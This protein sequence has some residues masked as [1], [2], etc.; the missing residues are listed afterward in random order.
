MR[1]SAFRSTCLAGVVAL[2]AI[3]GLSA[4]SKPKPVAAGNDQPLTASVTKVETKTLDGGLSA[5]GLLVSREEV[6][7]TTEL[8]GYRVAKVLVDQGA[9]VTQGQPLVQLDDTLLRSQLAQSQA[10]VASQEANSERADA[11][12]RRVSGLDN[13]GVLSQEQIEE[14]RLAARTA[15]AQLASARAQLA[16]LKVREGMMTIRAPFAG[17]LL[18]KTVRPGDVATPS[19]VMFR[20]TRGG[21]VELNA[22]V[23][24]ASLAEVHP[25]QKAQVVLADGTAVAGIVRL[26][27]PQV[28]QATKL[29]H[30]RITL[31]QREDIRPG[32]FARATFT[33]RGKPVPV[34]PERALNYDAKGASVMVLG[35]GDR[36]HRVE[37]KTGERSGGYV[38][39]LSG[40]E[41][42]ATVV[43]GGASFLLDG[44]HVRPS[45]TGT[46]DARPASGATRR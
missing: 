40:P 9:V 3:T 41:P 14:R 36:V 43:L 20:M 39:I 4:C 30:A 5:S 37:V 15:K 32:G 6:A 24:E 26:V 11:E 25:G 17:R 31:P 16:D 7:I 18:D 42:G 44:D 27:S 45:A 34:L 21:E 8:S 33:T 29:G 22:E 28:E 13:L 12:A 46:V 35:E 23:P 19:L 2:A 1:T 10:S 38:A